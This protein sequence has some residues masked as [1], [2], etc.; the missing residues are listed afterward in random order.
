MYLGE[1][2]KLL[3]IF[4]GVKGYALSLSTRRIYQQIVLRENVKQFHLSIKLKKLI[5]PSL[6]LIPGTWAPNSAPL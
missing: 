1:F 5:K 3:N 2:A 6:V 4:I